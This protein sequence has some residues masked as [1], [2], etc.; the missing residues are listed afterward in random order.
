MIPVVAHNVPTGPFKGLTPFEDSD[1]DA[2]LFFG[3]EREREVIAAN[4]L[5]SRLTVLY[6]ASGV[7]KSSVLRA[8]VAHH[9]RA[10]A[11]RNLE[12]RGHPEFVV[13]VFD[14]WTQD[15][16]AALLDAVQSEFVDVFGPE[17]APGERAATPTDT[18]HDWTGRLDCDLLLVLDQTEE[19]FLYHEQ[20]EGAGTLAGELPELVTRP[21]LRV[22]VLLAIRDDA[23]AR[24]D[25]FKGRIPNL[26]ANY[27]RLDHLDKRAGR[28]AILGPIEQYNVLAQ[29]DSRAGIEPE[30]VEALLDETTTGRLILGQRGRG[31]VRQSGVRTRVEAPYLQLVLHRLWEEELA[32]GSSLMRLETLE[33]LGG[34]NEVVRTHL[35]RALSEFPTEDKDVAAD[36]FSHLVTPSGTK[37]AHGLHDLARY[38][39]VDEDRLEPIVTRLVHERILRPVAK[40]ANG[41]V[42]GGADTAP[43]EIF[44]DVLGEAVLD[45]R[46]RYE[47]E[48]RVALERA[49]SDRRHRRVLGILGVVI[50]ALAAMT[51]IAAYAVAQRSE[52]NK[53][54]ARATSAAAYAIEQQ[55]I[56]E[57]QTA[58]AEDATAEAV[59]E[60]EKARTAE[61]E[62]EYQRQ[63]AE[64]QKAA[65]EEG[66]NEAESQKA[67]AVRERGKAE[68]EASRAV[69]AT[70]DANRQRK[71][72]VS[73]R[74]TAVR[75]RRRAEARLYLAQAQAQLTKDPMQTLSLAL[76]AVSLEALPEAEKVLRD[77]LLEL[78]VQAILAGGKGAVTAATFSPNGS[79]VATASESGEA[80]IFRTSAV[81]LLQ[82]LPHGAP[83]SSIAFSP[84]GSLVATGGMDGTVRIWDL[85]QRGNLTGLAAVRPVLRH[86]SRVRTVEFS[87]D[88]RLLVTASDD[89]TVRVW[90]VASGVQLR[91]F[92]H[93]RGVRSARFSPDG[94]LIVTAPVDLDPFARVFDVATGAVAALEHPGAVTD[95]RFTPD[96]SR[97]V[98][99]GRRNIF[100]WQ[101]GTW[102]RLHLL[103]AHVSP[104]HG[105]SVS[106]DSTRAVSFDDS[107]I[108]R[109]WRLDTGALIPGYIRHENSIDSVVFSPDSSTVLTASTDLTARIWTGALS[110]FK[111]SL[112]G[113]REEV[114]SATFSPDGTR[115]LT[116][117]NDG[118]ARLW[119]TSTEPTLQ[120]LGSAK[121]TGGATSIDTSADGSLVASGG[122]D[123]KV[124]LWRSRGGLLRTVDHGARVAA[125]A[126]SADGTRLLSAG[127]N[128]VA[129]LWRVRDG[130][131]LASVAHGS[132]IRAA[133]LSADGR[134]IVTGGG[135]TARTWSSTGAAG[136]VLRHDGAVTSL[137]LSVDGS[138]L[139]TGSADKTARVWVVPTGKE[140]RMLRGHTDSV[141]SVAFSRDGARV[142][143][144][145]TDSTARV[146]ETSTG[147]FRE[148]EGHPDALTSVRFSPDGRRV[149]TASIDG[150]VR[151]WSVAGSRD[152][153]VFRG[154]VSQVADARFSPDGRWVV[155]AGP[156]AA[157]LF[158][159]ESGDRIFFLRGHGAPLAGALFTRGSRRILTAG[160]DGTVRTYVCGVCGSLPELRRLA[161]QS[162]ASV[163]RAPR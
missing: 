118:T 108:G 94:R 67:V 59:Q 78:R 38:A 92:E 137:A 39:H 161:K 56:A 105:V 32:V 131:L 7:G 8:G 64:I 125:V 71:R 35:E 133:A 41:S 50:V 155:T 127:E 21:G 106:P 12:T 46:T 20:E 45:W 58:K 102:R 140:V 65:A 141:V 89:R 68:F 60:A 87:P 3:R 93:P 143:T 81:A 159:A 99:S 112:V 29:P 157:G 144:A 11:K 30:L 55:A 119:R 150:Q 122:V 129:R 66:Q 98:S 111:T 83:V 13:V 52:A 163:A 1:R 62:A 63:Q 17:L 31:V 104:V 121:H 70:A 160:T 113:H 115:I 53:Q 149:V 134:V 69:A 48:R 90:D 4:L 28:A 18:L 47:S 107:G 117:S 85:A 80:R 37:I 123:G 49:E 10:M 77:G 100:V 156:S 84:D 124:L 24:L 97:V 14:E 27:L 15:P 9:L 132:A 152:S 57:A 145:S 151:N 114:S 2:V 43:Y 61:E 91:R 116:A 79:Q 126:L 86:D 139:V 5:A 96:N 6:G 33:R 153:V 101:R 22:S 42:N 142:A 128:G 16:M 88:G 40:R 23:L 26:F 135:T 54:A 25:R 76:K 82:R 154:H 158:F 138:R 74:T 51:A 162:L 44:H 146:W 95:A 19:Y 120:V 110:E 136:H 130:A 75:Q 148:L 103:V 147:E 73:E 34:A 72:A 36:V 109:M